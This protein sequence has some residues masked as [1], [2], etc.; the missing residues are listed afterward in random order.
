LFARAKKGIFHSTKGKWDWPTGGQFS[1]WFL[2]GGLKSNVNLHLGPFA[3]LNW[4]FYFIFPFY[5]SVF[6][7]LCFIF[8]V[9]SVFSFFFLYIYFIAISS[10]ILSLS[11][12][13][14]SLR[15]IN[16]HTFPNPIYYNW[17]LVLLTFFYSFSSWQLSFFSLVCSH[18]FSFLSLNK[19]NKEKLLK[20]VGKVRKRRISPFYYF[21]REE[22]EKNHSCGS[23][24]K[25]SYSKKILFTWCPT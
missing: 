17:Y 24:W 16:S 8:L 23:K 2:C 12:F 6:F 15:Y 10:S 13:L 19:K 25:G 21:E 9:C 3:S 18:Y 20:S 22:N 1:I 7:L 11:F 4:V 14:C 5:L